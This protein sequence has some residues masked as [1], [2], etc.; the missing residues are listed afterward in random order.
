MFLFCMQPRRKQKY[1]ICSHW[2]VLRLLQNFFRPWFH[3]KWG[4]ALAGKEKSGMVH[5]VSL[6]T[7]GVQV[8]LWD[9][10]RT[11]AIPER[12]TGVITT[13]RY[14]Y[15]RLPLPLPY[16]LFPAWRCCDHFFLSLC[17]SLFHLLLFYQRILVKM[18]WLDSISN[19]KL[20][21]RK[22]NEH[23]MYV[24]TCCDMKFVVCCADWSDT[25]AVGI[26]RCWSRLP[27]S[28]CRY[29]REIAGVFER[30]VCQL[31]WPHIFISFSRLKLVQRGVGKML[32]VF[33]VLI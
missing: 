30:T 26:C 1:K 7:R 9:P 31:L 2:K 33:F 3:V 22:T 29:V 27:S 10:L 4:P 16:T 8:K 28:I 18:L 13:R 19:K 12:F 17:L 14:T 15:P 24:V 20:C 11:R 6:R 23:F 5:S 25:A 32:F 21:E